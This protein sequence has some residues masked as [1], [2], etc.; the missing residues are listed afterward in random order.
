MD[1]FKKA[2]KKVKTYFSFINSDSK[3]KGIGVTGVLVAA[4]VIT[5]TI[6]L[7]YGFVKGDVVK[8]IAAA[9][10][11][12]LTGIGGAI[13]DLSAEFFSFVLRSSFTS[14][15]VTDNTVFMTAWAS[16]RDLTNMLIVLGFVVVGIATTL[17]VKDYEAK[18]V[19]P[20]LIGVALLIN[21]SGLLC[22]TI[23]SAANTT[24]TALLEQGSASG[25]FM[26][27]KSGVDQYVQR[28]MESIGEIQEQADSPSAFIGKSAALA[29]FEIFS[30]YIFFIFGLLITVRY[31]MLAVLYILS[32]LAFFCM[33]FSVTNQYW[34]QWWQ[35]YLKWA[36]TGVVAAFFIYLSVNVLF[37]AGAGNIQFQTMMVSFI[38]LYV[39][40]KLSKGGGAIG[41]TAMLGLA[42]TAA[43]VAMGGGLAVAKGLSN[44]RAGQA[45]GNIGGRA[46]ESMG[47]RQEGLT[48]ANAAKRQEELSKNTQNLSFQ[49]QIEIGKGRGM[50]A[51]TATGGAKREAVIRDFAKN[52]NLHELGDQKAQQDAIGWVEARDKA[53]G[54]GST[55]RKDAAKY[56]P[57]LAA[58]ESDPKYATKVADSVNKLSDRGF[59]DNVHHSAYK[60]EVIGALREGQIENGVFGRYG[61]KAKQDKLIE[62]ANSDESVKYAEKLKNSD[63]VA[64]NNYRRN[65]ELINGGGSTATTTAS[66][67]SAT[68]TPLP[69][70]ARGAMNPG[71]KIPSPPPAANPLT[72]S[73]GG[74]DTVEEGPYKGQ[75]VKRADR[76]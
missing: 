16:V 50:G 41:A 23:E 5:A 52:G 74:G 11:A 70:G 7:I 32:P 13:F 58:P 48:A 66:T 1:P 47:M 42:G 44:T 17:R 40:Y 53:R 14:Q 54:G 60:P 2:F 37:S 71:A 24:M 45:I 69:T 61:T 43:T 29:V 51:W 25:N 75:Q 12:V 64:Y 27:I 39:G 26:S 55:I 19:L 10:A 18:K 30:G 36:F 28:E 68:P 21:F 15:S 67:S 49:R 56:N 46:L 8:G 59:A 65:V 35:E 38:F 31:A 63:I 20:W 9:F 62:A 33:V 34:K 4:A 76:L 73:V 72:H 57:N 3:E 6:G 22:K